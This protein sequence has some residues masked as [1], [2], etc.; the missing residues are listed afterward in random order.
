MSRRICIS[1]LSSW[2]W[3]TCK[4]PFT[5]QII[6]SVAPVS[7]VR[8]E[9]PT[10]CLF[11]PTSSPFCV[12]VSELV[13]I[14][15]TEAYS[16]SQ[17]LRFDLHRRLS[18]GPIQNTGLQVAFI[19]PQGSHLFLMYILKGARAWP[20]LLQRN[21]SIPVTYQAEVPRRILVG[22]FSAKPERNSLRVAWS[23][24]KATHIFKGQT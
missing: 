21:K 24:Q 18:R 5:T 20:K 13:G 3:H 9:A 17:G 23:V 14:L 15:L 6:V 10:P 2:N 8:L 4:P 11:L 19:S 12:P 1:I 22:Q 16:R 7:L